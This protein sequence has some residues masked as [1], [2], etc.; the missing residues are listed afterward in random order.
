MDQAQDIGPITSKRMFGGVGLFMH[1][2]MF[3]LLADDVLYLKADDGNRERFQ[4]AG[5]IPFKPWPDKPPVMPYWEVPMEVLEDED[6][7]ADWATGSLEATL[8]N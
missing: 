7:L 8:K 5:C 2:K 3:A 6:L 1:G 4:S